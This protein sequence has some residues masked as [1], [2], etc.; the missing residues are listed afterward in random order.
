MHCA[1]STPH[2]ANS[3]EKRVALV[4]G[5]SKEFP[6][7][8]F[9][10][11]V[12][13]SA[14]RAGYTFDYYPAEATTLG[15]FTNLP[16]LN[17][18]LII[19]RTHGGFY[20]PLTT[21]Q[22]YSNQ[23]YVASQLLDEVGAVNVSGTVYFSMTPKGITNLLCGQFPG[24]VIL[25]MGCGSDSNLANQGS[26]FVGRG[27]RVLLAWDTWVGIYH[28]D[29]AY[30]IVTKMLLESNTIAASIQGSLARIGPDPLYG[31]NLHYFPGT[32]AQFVL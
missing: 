14:S 12:T 17:Y 9:V 29:L 1:A 28:S 3:V 31:A 21:S 11:N 30:E 24:T 13:A 4:D 25:A 18:S 26:A 10:T 6:D 32:E 2:M 16:M 15:L 20:G 19:L 23:Q 7:R 22:P 27:A 5:L 8:D